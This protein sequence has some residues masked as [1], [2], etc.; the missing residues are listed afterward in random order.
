MRLTK[1]PARGARTKSWGPL[2]GLSLLGCALS[3]ALVVLSVVEGDGMSLV[4]TLLLSCL[5]SLVGYGAKWELQL[6]KRTATRQVPPGDVVIYY[7]QGSFLVVKCE[8]EVARELY[9]VPE[10]CVYQVS[11]QPYRLLAL[12][13]TI[14]LMFGVIFLANSGLVMQLCFGGSYIILN[15]AYWGVAALPKQTHWDLSAYKVDV[16]ECV[17]G[18]E[19]RTFTEA[20]WKAIAITGSMR[21]AKISHIPPQST[22]WDEWLERAEQEAVRFPARVEKNGVLVLPEWDAGGVLTELLAQSAVEKIV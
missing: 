1:D 18:E 4:A 10:T 5:S 6:S 15:V 20:L 2:T 3:I 16:V 12:T 17:G 22:Q 13:G 8:E 9:W 7:P 21:W 19:N 11:E 14:M